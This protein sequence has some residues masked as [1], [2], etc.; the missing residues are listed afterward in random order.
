M[1]EWAAVDDEGLGQ[2]AQVVFFFVL[3]FFFRLW[4]IDVVAFLDPFG[5]GGASTPHQNF[6]KGQRDLAV[7]MGTAAPGGGAGGANGDK[8]VERESFGVI[9]GA[10]RIP[11]GRVRC[12]DDGFR[13]V[14]VFGPGTRPL[15]VCYYCDI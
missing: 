15:C 4:L 3:A 13:H 12:V 9:F 2:I 10:Q 6:T 5:A 1:G 7:I 11:S 8:V 14:F